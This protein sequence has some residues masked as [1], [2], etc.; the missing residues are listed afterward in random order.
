M[1]RAETRN[2]RA[3][4]ALI[5][6][7]SLL[8]VAAVVYFGWPVFS[9]FTDP[10]RARQL[11][12]EF[13]VWGP[14]VFIGMQTAQVLLA[15]IPGQV[16]GLVGGF[17]F[18]TFWGVVYTMIGA[19]IGFTLLFLLAKRFG[20]PLA[21]RLVKPE[22]LDRFDHLAQKGG[23]LVLFLVFLL[24]AFPDDVIS[25]IAGMTPIR[26]RTLILVSLAGRLPGYLV[27]SATG[28]GVAF[29]NMNLILALVGATILIFGFAY[30]NRAWLYEMAVSGDVRGFLRERWPL[31]TRATVLL[32]ASVVAAVV[33]LFVFATT[34]PQLTL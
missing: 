31:S 4:R 29:E 16:S 27:L 5:A 26:L 28:N 22:T 12:E 14:L 2:F 33:L 20:R 23:V 6:V 30:W 1:G 15:P 3:Y 10:D 13:G 8:G 32:A 9:T 18:G 21:E 24:P 34:S 19:A 7:V 25:L 11:V 17:L